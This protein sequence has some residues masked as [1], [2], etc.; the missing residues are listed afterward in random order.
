M[1]LDQ[2]E[3]NNGIAGI[4]L[5]ALFGNPSSITMRV[6]GRIHNHEVVSLLD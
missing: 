3:E 4:T 6:K 5:Y 1:L 2:H